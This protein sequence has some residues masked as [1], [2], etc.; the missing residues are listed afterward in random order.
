MHFGGLA[1]ARRL[2]ELSFHRLQTRLVSQRVDSQPQRQVSLCHLCIHLK[3]DQDIRLASQTRV[4]LSNCPPDSAILPIPCF[5]RRSWFARGP[6]RSVVPVTKSD[7]KIGKWI[8]ISAVI[9]QTLP[10]QRAVPDPAE[11]IWKPAAIHNALSISFV[12]EA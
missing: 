9:Q 1:Q 4:F 2:L 5:I 12:G 6:T 11:S 7:A 10:N 8:R 3:W